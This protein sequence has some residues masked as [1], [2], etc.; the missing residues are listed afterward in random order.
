MWGLG[1]E[2]E[3]DG[4]GEV[5]IFVAGRGVVV[6]VRQGEEDVGPIGWVSGGGGGGLAW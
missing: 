5:V 1:L 4:V 2:R 3:S 6:G